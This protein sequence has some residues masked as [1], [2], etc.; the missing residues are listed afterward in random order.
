MR[1]PECVK[2]SAFRNFTGKPNHHA[3]IF[4][5]NFSGRGS[6]NVCIRAGTD[7]TR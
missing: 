7:P 5:G 6:A 1:G 4:F 2:P 3:N